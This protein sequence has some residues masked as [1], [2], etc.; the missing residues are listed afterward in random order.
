MAKSAE[1]SFL[2]DL[3]YRLEYLGLRTLVGMVRLVPVDFGGS[4][5]AKCWRFLGARNHRHK[6]ALAN[7]Y[8][9]LTRR[10]RSANRSRSPR[11][12]ISDG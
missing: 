5:S 4:I 3:R 8:G 12:K 10:R 9:R 1:I 7:L 2:L 11:G 6:R